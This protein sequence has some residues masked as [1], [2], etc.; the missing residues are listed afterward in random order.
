[1][2]N[3]TSFGH[4]TFE[5]C[6]FVWNSTG[7]EQIVMASFVLLLVSHPGAS[8]TSAFQLSVDHAKS[9]QFSVFSQSVSFDYDVLIVHI[10]E[11]LPFH[12]FFAMVF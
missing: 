5:C 10:M 1:M 4:P 7:F 12:S 3:R 6:L 2:T 9:S 11:I 8:H